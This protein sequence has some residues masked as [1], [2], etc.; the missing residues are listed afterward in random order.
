MNMAN[1]KLSR[2]SHL[3]LDID[4]TIVNKVG[5]ISPA[6]LT[7]IAMAREAGITV[8]ICTGR[9]TGA[10]QKILNQLRLTGAHIFFD[11]TLVYDPQEDLEIYSRSLPQELV[12]DMVDYALKENLPLDLFSRN[13]YFALKEDWRTEIR[14]TFFNVT[15]KVTDFRTILKQA[16]IIKGGI[17]VRTLEEIESAKRF[18]DRFRDRVNLTWTVTPALAGIQFINI[19]DKS[20]S[21]G[22]A[23][24]VLC[25]HL[26]VPIEKVCAIGD[27]PNDISLLSAAGFGVAMQ[28]SSAELKAVADYVTEDV[29]DNGVAEAIRRFLL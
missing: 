17:A 23:L 20:A 1:N 27:G 7:A 2:C 6:D 18:A 5:V 28:N 13:E 19:V 24:K 29:S 10:S 8:T 3:V 22:N 21:K 26:A 15:G 9:S 4:G 25:K 16:V 14:R 11:G 12:K